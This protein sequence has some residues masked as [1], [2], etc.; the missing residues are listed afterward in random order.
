MRFLPPIPMTVISRFALTAF[1]IPLV[2]LT[3]CTSPVTP[4][5]IAVT[6]AKQPPMTETAL[7]APGEVTK[8]LKPDSANSEAAP[9]TT[10]S[11]K[12]DKPDSKPENGTPKNGGTEAATKKATD[13]VAVITFDDLNINM[14]QDIVFRPWMLTDRVKE[15]E[16]K[17]I[18][19]NGYM[20]GGISQLKN[21]KEFVLLK[22]TECKFGPG[23]Q[24][25]H[26]IQVKLQGNASASYGTTPV[27]V[28]GILKLNPYQGPDGNTWSVYDLLGDAVKAVRK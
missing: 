16:G 9:P 5:S 4:P 28:E 24:A 6:P 12:S 13:E 7:A 18:R 8:S 23:G 11:E 20:H 26:L 1:S 17:R 14:Q 22:N 3:S 10:S 19:L 21:I 15:L 2:M 27:Q 25:D